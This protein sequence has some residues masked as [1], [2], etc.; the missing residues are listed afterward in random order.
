MSILVL[1]S[2]CPYLI[3]FWLERISCSS[4]VI[5]QVEVRRT[6]TKGYGGAATGDG[7]GKIGGRSPPSLPSLR[8]SEGTESRNSPE[9]RGGSRRGGDSPPSGGFGGMVRRW[10][11]V[12]EGRTDRAESPRIDGPS[13]PIY[14]RGTELLRRSSEGP[15]QTE[16]EEGHRPS[17][18]WRGPGSLR[19]FRRNPRDPG[20]IPLKEWRSHDW[21]ERRTGGP[22]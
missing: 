15:T 20:R 14:A 1:V 9:H 18:P 22:E 7:E 16:H 13:R 3:C 2:L 21:T 4:A 17:G 8:E 11:E 10:R 12:P 5:T 6:E 19:G